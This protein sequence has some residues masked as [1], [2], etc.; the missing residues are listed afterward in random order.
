MLLFNFA[1]HDGSR[2]ASE[3]HNGG[4][5]GVGSSFVTITLTLLGGERGQYAD[6]RGDSACAELAGG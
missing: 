5:S 4:K 3:G 6:V 2:A 1:D